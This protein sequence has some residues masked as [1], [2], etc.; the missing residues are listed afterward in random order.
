MKYQKKEKKIHRRKMVD[1]KRFTR[2][3]E[4]NA[5]PFNW[6]GPKYL[7]LQQKFNKIRICE[8]LEQS[9][10]HFPSHVAQNMWS[11]ILAYICEHLNCMWVCYP[12]LLQLQAT[13]SLNLACAVITASELGAWLAESEQIS[14]YDSRACLAR[15]VQFSR[16]FLLHLERKTAATQRQKF[17][18]DFLSTKHNKMRKLYGPQKFREHIFSETRN[19]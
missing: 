12:S 9:Y 10:D 11:K 17:W 7:N 19:E 18:T 14:Q 2:L 6:R 4:R 8:E 15:K 1:K 3:E 13:P 16:H 5:F